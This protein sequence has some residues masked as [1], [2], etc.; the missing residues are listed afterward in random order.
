MQNYNCLK[1]RGKVLT[2]FPDLSFYHGYKKTN[3]LEQNENTS[4]FFFFIPF[5]RFGNL[6]KVF[7]TNVFK[8]PGVFLM[9]NPKLFQKKNWT[10]FDLLTYKFV[11]VH[12][13]NCLNVRL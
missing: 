6:Q 13:Y 7:L 3:M 4:I 12:I 1:P 9:P 10:H 5:P 8:Q 11:L 2:Q